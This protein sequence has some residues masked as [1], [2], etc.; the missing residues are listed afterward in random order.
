MNPEQVFP[1]PNDCIG[2]YVFFKHI[3]SEEIPDD[4][5]NFELFLSYVRQNCKRRKDMDGMVISTGV[6]FDDN[7]VLFKCEAKMYEYKYYLF[8]IRRI[9]AYLV[10]HRLAFMIH[11]HRDEYQL[12]V[13]YEPRR[14]FSDRYDIEESVRITI[15]DESIPNWRRKLKSRLIIIRSKAICLI[16]RIVPS[17]FRIVQSRNNFMFDWKYRMLCR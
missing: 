13:T 2:G 1:S 15:R 3:F 9:D 16:N 8:P 4:E 11:E 6:F 17:Y 5:D 10:L 12:S 7:Q 14:P